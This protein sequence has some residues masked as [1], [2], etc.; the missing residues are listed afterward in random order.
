M[1]QLKFNLD[2]LIK[3]LKQSLR[4]SDFCGDFLSGHARKQF[5]ETYYVSYAYPAR[6]SSM[7]LCN[8]EDLVYQT[9]TGS[10]S[11]VCQKEKCQNL[12]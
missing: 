11:R 1:F 12:P 4:Q 10:I 9:A 6:K 5:S 3:K 8:F 7:L 2:F